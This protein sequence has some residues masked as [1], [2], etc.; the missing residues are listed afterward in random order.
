MPG[1]CAT[2]KAVHVQVQPLQSFGCCAGAWSGSVVVVALLGVLPGVLFYVPMP[3]LSF[4]HHL[5][6]NFPFLFSL[7]FSHLLLLRALVFVT[8]QEG[9]LL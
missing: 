6:E 1:C 2:G 5:V 7:L 8:D 9:M 4:H 3:R